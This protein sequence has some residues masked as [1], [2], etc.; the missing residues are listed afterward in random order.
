[1]EVTKKSLQGNKYTFLKRPVQLLYQ[2]KDSGG[3]IGSALNSYRVIW[4]YSTCAQQTDQ[5]NCC[6]ISV[7]LHRQNYRNIGW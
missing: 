5:V 2:V 6:G 1:M 3:L 7:R 4:P